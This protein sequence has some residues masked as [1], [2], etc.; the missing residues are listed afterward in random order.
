MAV[1]TVTVGTTGRDYSTLQSAYDDIDTIT[2]SL[3][4]VTGT[5]SVIFD[6]Y[7]DS[8]FTERVSF[9]GVTASATYNVTIRKAST[10]R[11]KW[12]PSSGTGHVFNIQDDFIRFEGIDVFQWATGDAGDECVRLTNL[13]EGTFF[14]K[15]K[16]GPTGVVN[17]LVYFLFANVGTASNPVTFRDCLFQGGGFASLYLQCLFGP[18]SQYCDLINCT[19]ATSNDSAIQYMMRNAGDN[20]YLTIKNSIFLGYF[21]SQDI[22]YDGAGDN[23]GTFTTT[24]STNNF[25][26]ASS[27]L[28]PGLGTPNPITET[29]S[30]SPGAGDWAMF[31]DITGWADMHLVDDT[32]NDVIGGGVGPSSDSDV[33][34]TDIEG[35]ARSGTTC[36]P[37][38]Y[39]IA[40][41]GR[42][43]DVSIT[44]DGDTS[45]ASGTLIISAV[46]S[47]TEDGDTMGAEGM[48]I[49]SGV[50][51][52]TED[53][54][55]S[56]AGGTLAITGGAS[57]TEDGD[58][59]SSL[60]LSGLAAYFEITEAG[61]SLTAAGVGPDVL[62]SV[63]SGVL[64][65][66]NLPS[67]DFRI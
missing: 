53:G 52:I 11:P 35:V 19:F 49:I 32:D 60:L 25:V 61:D 15:C 66:D 67:A 59:V 50:V 1:F 2:G 7:D 44:E 26:K 47:L 17:N 8:V 21:G 58:T 48:L 16:F 33:S 22:F 64:S 51:S 30:T 9:D 45:S 5:D 34:S 23:L 27:G 20:I 40:A 13:A 54:D 46:S 43:A 65:L 36:E 28:V 63:H 55:T 18:I 42:T 62:A 31:A 12:Q 57:I 37:G 14:D 39:E 56:S 29:E 3:D 6:V 24:G 4:L 41:S 38:C 10:G